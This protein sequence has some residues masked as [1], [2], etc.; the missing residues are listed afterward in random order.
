MGSQ[1][2]SKNCW[3]FDWIDQKI[4]KVSNL[5]TNLDNNCNLV[6]F[7]NVGFVW[8]EQDDV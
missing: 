7:L 4:G 3:R 8:I 6:A 5:D 2:G 1:N